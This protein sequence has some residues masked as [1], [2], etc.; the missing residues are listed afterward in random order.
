[1]TYSWGYISLALYLAS[2]ACYARIL[3]APDNRLGRIATALLAGGILLQ[4][5]DLLARSQWTRTVPYDDL[6]GSMSLFA[7]LLGLTYLGLEIFHRQ[8]SV[9]VLVTFLLVVWIVGL[10]LIAP[11][12]TPAP[13]QPTDRCL[14][15]TLR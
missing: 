4:Y 14:P 6:Y 11:N 7:W 13:P 8:R 12:G 2:F 5:V 10:R 1:M 15:C 3:Y 9:G